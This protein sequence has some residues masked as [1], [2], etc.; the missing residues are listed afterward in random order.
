MTRD[1]GNARWRARW[2]ALRSSGLTM[3]E[4]AQRE[5][6]ARR[7]PIGGCAK[8]GAVGYGRMSRS[9]GRKWRLRSHERPRYLRAWR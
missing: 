1:E 9:P 3:K 7:V 8:H 5:D 6:F 2:Q 4:F